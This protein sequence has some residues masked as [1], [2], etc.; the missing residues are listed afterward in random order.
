MG[1]FD[2]KKLLSNRTAQK[3]LL[4]ISCVCLLPLW[5][6]LRRGVSPLPL[7]VKILGI[8]AA[9]I[10]ILYLQLKPWE[11]E[12]AE[13]KRQQLELEAGRS[14]DDGGSDPQE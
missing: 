5:I 10:F 1:G 9:I 3:C 13:K 2:V 14:A 6:M 7:V 11:M 4:P 8:L 12:R